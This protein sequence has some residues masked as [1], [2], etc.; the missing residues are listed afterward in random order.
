MLASLPPPTPFYPLPRT[1]LLSGNECSGDSLLDLYIAIFFYSL[2][3]LPVD[4]F[5][6][7]TSLTLL[8]SQIANLCTLKIIVLNLYLLFHLFI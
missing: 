6:L 8:P 3:Q 4:P 2:C 5:Y 1:T 7:F